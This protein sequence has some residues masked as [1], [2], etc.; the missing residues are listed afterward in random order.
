MLITTPSC[1]LSCSRRKQ[2]IVQVSSALQTTS[3]QLAINTCG[4]Q[5]NRVSRPSKHGHEDRVWG[6]G[7]EQCRRHRVSSGLRWQL[8][9]VNRALMIINTS[10]L[11]LIHK[12]CDQIHLQH[13]STYFCGVKV[14]SSGNSKQWKTGPNEFS[15]ISQYNIIDKL[16]KLRIE[17]SLTVNNKLNYN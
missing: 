4:R 8:Y 1:V 11:L 12:Y 9:L 3:T 14:G 16:D 15:L 10:L 5:V 2:L 7:W 6:C 17:K 13:R